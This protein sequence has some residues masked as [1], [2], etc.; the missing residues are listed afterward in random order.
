MD[1]AELEDTARI[2]RR[3]AV[4]AQIESALLA[5]RLEVTEMPRRANGTNP[6]DSGPARQSARSSDGWGSKRR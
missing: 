3:H 5:G 4:L 2:D 1:S 6:Y